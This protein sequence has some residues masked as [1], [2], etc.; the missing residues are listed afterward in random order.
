MFSY[1]L[2][3]HFRGFATAALAI[4]LV[5]VSLNKVH[6][7]ELDALGDLA[8]YTFNYERWSV[9]ADGDVIESY[10]RTDDF[11]DQL[12]RARDSISTH[13][14]TLM[15]VRPTILY[16]EPGDEF[17]AAVRAEIGS[18]GRR[19]VDYVDGNPS[20]GIAGYLGLGDFSL[21]VANGAT[22]DAR[23]APVSFYRSV[24]APSFQDGTYTNRITRA[25]SAGTLDASRLWQS[26]NAQILV[27][28]FNGGEVEH[29]TV[30]FRFYSSVGS[31]GYMTDFGGN[32]HQL[33]YN[34]KDENFQ[35][36]ANLGWV[37]GVQDR[38]GN[39]V[40][41]VWLELNAGLLLRKNWTLDGSFLTAFGDT[42]SS[43][44]WGKGSYSITVGSSWEFLENHH[45]RGEYTYADRVTT[46][47]F[48]REANYIRSQ[49]MRLVYGLQ[50]SRNLYAE[51]FTT[52][53]DISS[54]QGNSS[55]INTHGVSA[56][57]K[58]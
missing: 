25:I 31:F 15:L 46:N 3:S 44:A 1:S 12:G 45:I 6:S 4:F 8:E 10:R 11:T 21:T 33:E 7:N 47:R 53:G 43:S 27:D 19:R 9:W 20:A 14:D 37:N 16:G 36:N 55:T 40:D 13:P 54:R 57:F 22:V 58:F 50:F 34:F 56:G 51:A 29:E 5:S 35:V 41:D 32:A 30:A 18:E 52:F 42:R 38:W 39:E 26:M 17:W 2:F 28:D 48:A 49:S 24:F 23:F